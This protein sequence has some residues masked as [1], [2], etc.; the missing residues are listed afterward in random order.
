[1]QVQGYLSENEILRQEKIE[2]LRSRKQAG[3]DGALDPLQADLIRDLNQ[4]LEILMAENATMAEQKALLA[5]ELENTSA[6]LHRRTLEVEE[7]AAHVRA[8]AETVSSLQ[9][10]LQRTEKERDEAA[11][12]AVH[13]SDALG[14][15]STE[16]ETLKEALALQQHKTRDLEQT[17]NELTLRLKQVSDKYEE[18]Q[19]EC[20]RRVRKAED[21]VREL[22]T[23]LLQKTQELD[24]LS[25]SN[26]KL[27]R[28]Y[29][30][31]R[32]DAE[33]MVQ[34][35]L[36][37]V[38][39]CVR[40]TVFVFDGWVCVCV[41]VCVRLRVYSGDECSP[42]TSGRVCGARRRCEQTQQGEQ[43][44][45]RGGTQCEGPGVYLLR[46]CVCLSLCML[47]VCLAFMCVCASLHA[48]VCLNFIVVFQALVRE[49]QCKRDL[50][51][52]LEER[53]R[54]A[55]KRQA[56]IDAAVENAR[57]RASEQFQALDRDLKEM[58]E[59]NA[60]LKGVCVRMCV[61][62]WYICVCVCVNILHVGLCVCV[63]TECCS[64]MRSRH[65]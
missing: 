14:K 19:L 48:G 32:A 30:S 18:E 25:E 49:E 7:L 44:S 16:M 45:H 13:F 64:G 26:R 57:Q 52:L 29:A 5:Q 55:V 22:H 62:V 17:S 1:L 59:K 46:M 21:R 3:S 20:M 40:T 35:C 27:K 15:A 60:I 34:V 61:Y 10:Q 41:C 33:G 2:Y 31:T 47:C 11:K 50:N 36:Y 24:T 54:L 23:Q 28:E 63:T 38:N 56:D 6:D 4:K 12:Q 9:L 43:G 39:R 58:A 65:S 51:R 42:A 8:S 53:T 37:A